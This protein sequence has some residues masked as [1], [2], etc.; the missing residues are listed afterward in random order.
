ME[1][2]SPQRAPLLRFVDGVP[3][4][5]ASAN[6]TAIPRPG[7]RGSWA[8][9]H[10]PQAAW[11]GLQD[12]AAG[13]SSPQPPPQPP[14]QPPQPQL[15][16]QLQ[17]QQSEP[18]LPSLTRAPAV[19][20]SKEWID[21]KKKEREREDSWDPE[22]S[23][24][25]SGGGSKLKTQFHSFPLTA[26]MVNKGLRVRLKADAQKLGRCTRS[27]RGKVGG[28]DGKPPTYEHLAG[29]RVQRLGARY[30]DVYS[31]GTLRGLVASMHAQQNGPHAWVDKDPAAEDAPL[32][33]EST[34]E[35]M[36]VHLERDP[37]KGGK[38]MMLQNEGRWC[39]VDFP[40]QSLLPGDFEEVERG[41][42]P[43][44]AQTFKYLKDFTMDQEPTGPTWVECC[45][46]KAT[47]L[48]GW[49]PLIQ[50][51]ARTD[52]LGLV[53]NDA[54][55]HYRGQTLVKTAAEHA[56]VDSM[57]WVPLSELTEDYNE[58]R[59]LYRP[60]YGRSLPPS[61]KAVLRAV[62]AECCGFRGH[63]RKSQREL[64]KE[65]E[66][67]G[68]AERFVTESSS[69]YTLYSPAT[70]AWATSWNN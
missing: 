26:A 17:P 28:D 38:I 58:V 6:K 9:Q 48:A 24:G 15:Q 62:P 11:S 44:W 23:R 30:G 36:T 27:I 7:S 53:A 67:A 33:P 8:P 63:R 60:D 32:T 42:D 21:P 5:L 70:R 4:V 16:P 12:S 66:V 43:T 1:P 18:E 3:M 20:Q 10:V 2:L 25:F 14:R 41:E 40:Q 57:G 59:Y 61:R 34:V 19:V 46:L 51:T 22:F 52:E 50:L 37:A 55:K 47:P 39:L 31:R 56:L 54:F 69:N 49:V 13:P 35:G 45:H 65:K 29:M 68:G 64:D